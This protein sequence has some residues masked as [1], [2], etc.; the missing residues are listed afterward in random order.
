MSTKRRPE[1]ELP[2][3]VPA[4]EFA[5]KIG[6]YQRKALVQPV[7]ITAHGK[8][9]LVVLNAEEYQRLKRRDRRVLRVEELDDETL[10]A[11]A[12]QLSAPDP[13]ATALDRE[14]DEPTP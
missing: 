3:Q 9:S 4:K 11:I 12:V 6:E 14:L 1:D 7:T 13:E 10:D 2:N 8:P 5:R